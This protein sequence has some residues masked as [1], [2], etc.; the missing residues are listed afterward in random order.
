M[1]CRTNVGADR[2]EVLRKWHVAFLAPARR[3]GDQI[4]ES[5]VRTA[6]CR[7]ARTLPGMRAW[8]H[9]LVASDSLHLLSARCHS[10]DKQ[11]ASGDHA[12]AGRKTVE[13][14]DRVAIG[15]PDLDP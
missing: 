2:N 10:I 3:S 4:A 15:K 13:H 12:I 7:R 5:T 1:H 9:R 8:C 6:A 11:A 14:L